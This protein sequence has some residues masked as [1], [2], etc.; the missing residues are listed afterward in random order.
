[1]FLLA[2]LGLL[3]R[4]IEAPAWKAVMM[5]QP[6][7]NLDALEGTLGQGLII[8]VLG[9]FRAIL[10]DFLWIRTNVIWERKDRIKL[11]SMVRLV[12]TLD[13][14]PD[15]FWINGSSKALLMCHL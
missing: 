5:G 3:A 15:F 13:P 7:I 8:G 12:T 6:E 14:R 10:A 1:M 2:L 9:G 4:P 11:D